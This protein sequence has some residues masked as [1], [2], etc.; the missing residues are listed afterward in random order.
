MANGLH[1]GDRPYNFARMYSEV[2]VRGRIYPDEI[3]AMLDTGMLGIGSRKVPFRDFRDN[4][5]HSTTVALQSWAQQAK[6][7]ASERPHLSEVKLSPLGSNTLSARWQFDAA[8]IADA[9]SNTASNRASRQL[10]KLP[11]VLPLRR[12]Q[13]GS[14]E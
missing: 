7:H 13:C 5:P 14:E 3:V 1:S 4:L 10:V 11:P 9:L 8:E 12:P 6:M 2:C